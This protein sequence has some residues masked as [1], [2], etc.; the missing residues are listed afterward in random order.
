MEDLREFRYHHDE[1]ERCNGSSE[2]HL[3]SDLRRSGPEDAVVDLA[4]SRLDAKNGAFNDAVDD[5]FQTVT[6]F[7]IDDTNLQ[8]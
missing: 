2:R 7:T 8:K 4:S 3:N 1:F 5:V 6:R